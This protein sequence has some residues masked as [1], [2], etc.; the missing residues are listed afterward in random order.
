MTIY[1]AVVVGSGAGGASSAWKLAQGG[2][3]VCVIEQGRRF[4]T[5]DSPV[6]KPLGSLERHRNLSPLPSVRRDP[7]DLLV[8]TTSAEIEVSFF[9][10]VGGSTHVY[11]GHFPRFRER[12]F[13]LAS[14]HGLG[15]DWPLSYSDLKSH[16]EFNEAKMRVAG[17][18]GDPKYPEISKLY[19]I[20][21]IGAFGEQLS[22]SFHALGWHVWPSYSAVD[23]RELSGSKCTDLGPCNLGCPVGAKSTAANRYLEE[24]E[25]LGGEVLSETAAIRVV[26]DKSKATGVMVRDSLGQEATIHGA[27]IV[28]A[29]GAI[30]TPALLFNS[31]LDRD[32]PHTGR[33]LMLH[34]LA[35]AEGI[36]PQEIDALRGPEGSWLYSLEFEFDEVRNEPGFM[37]QVLRGGDLLDNAR[38][39]FQMRKLQFG[40][41]FGESI[42][43][44]LGKRVSI[45]L[46]FEDLPD[47]SNRLTIDHSSANSF[48]FPGVKI[49][50][51]VDPSLKQRIPGALDKARKVLS[52]AGAS[53]TRGYGPVRGTGWHPSGT[54]RMGLSQADS[55]CTSTGR[56]HTMSNVFVSDSSLFPTGSCVNPANTIQSLSLYIAELL[57][58]GE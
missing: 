53:R 5:K 44:E 40:S 58:K 20:S 27:L 17:R 46:V 28:L 23:R 19:G 18:T 12:D 15:V 36:F 35:L 37:M 3:K 34:P 4:S 57:L 48:G 41:G 54:A 25:L 49:E 29:A 33:N 32:L 13:S 51:R 42:S 39:A 1:D 30:G 2:M 16:Y 45:A 21:P 24:F 8:D 11:S 31:E 10:A 26:H 6:L 43:A 9:Q 56:L 14:S 55:V 7:D 52:H 38:R 47:Y 50:Y 22:E